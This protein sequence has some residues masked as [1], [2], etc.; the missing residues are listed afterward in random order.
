MFTTSEDKSRSEVR[1]YEV[2]EADID[3]GW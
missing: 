3:K 1:E 2:R